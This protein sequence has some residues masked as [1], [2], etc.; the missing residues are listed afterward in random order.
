MA[1]TA[2]DPRKYNGLTVGEL[3][4]AYAIESARELSQDTTL[5]PQWRARHR[6]NLAAMRQ[7]FSATDA[8]R[9]N[10]Q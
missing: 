2:P 10:A 5:P 9:G 8:T 3:L 6:K 4:V 1:R 7:A